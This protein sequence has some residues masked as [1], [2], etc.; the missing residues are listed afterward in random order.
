MLSLGIAPVVLTPR[1]TYGSIPIF[2]CPLQ[3]NIRS[4]ATHVLSYFSTFK[5]DELASNEMNNVMFNWC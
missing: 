2:L 3:Q 4:D 1:F 5:V